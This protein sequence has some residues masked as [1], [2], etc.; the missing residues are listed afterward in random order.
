MT[1]HETDRLSA[2]QAKADE[3]VRA[4]ADH[5]GGPSPR[6]MVAVIDPKTNTR[7]ATGF[8]AYSVEADRPPL[9]LVPGGGERDLLEAVLEALT[10]PYETPN[11]RLRILDRACTARV[12]VREALAEGSVWDAAEHAEFLRDRIRKE[13]AHYRGGGQS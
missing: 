4:V 13:E 2:A 6:L 8:V 3:V 7:L 5:D 9:R 11:R 12:S 10:L 1:A